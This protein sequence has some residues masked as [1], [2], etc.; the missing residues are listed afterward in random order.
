[1]VKHE[2]RVGQVVEFNPSGAGVPAPARGYK[3]LRLLPSEWGERLYQIK[4]ITEPLVRVAKESELSL[5]SK[6]CGHGSVL[7]FMSG[8]ASVALPATSDLE[9]PPVDLTK[10][11]MR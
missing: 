9:I 4:T 6:G 3:I 11:G 8:A 1:M 10:G 5:G 2:F 7:Q